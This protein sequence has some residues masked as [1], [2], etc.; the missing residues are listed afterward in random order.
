MAAAARRR[1]CRSRA[2]AAACTALP[3]VVVLLLLATAGPHCGAAQAVAN[4]EKSSPAANSTAK[5]AAGAVAATTS[6]RTPPRLPPPAVTSSQAAAAAW[7]DT[8]VWVTG[9]APTAGARGGKLVP[10]P[11]DGAPEYAPDQLAQA[12][13]MDGIGQAARIAGQN[14]GA[15]LGAEATAGNSNNNNNNNNG[16]GNNNGTSGNDETIIYSVTRDG[17]DS[18]TMMPR[19]SGCGSK[20]LQRF[21]VV[22]HPP[23][24]PSFPCPMAPSL[25]SSQTR[26]LLLL[27]CVHI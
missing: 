9:S 15:I 3:L 10:P 11:A 13:S 12:P 20:Q 23:A 22:F 8:T 2:A 18:A 7:H 25:T 16:N 19:V 1:R 6:S 17:P 14:A 26:T 27:Y 21:R 4:D 24:S 5:R